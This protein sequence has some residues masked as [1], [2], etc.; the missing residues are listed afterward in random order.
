[1]YCVENLRC[2]ANKIIVSASVTVS[3]LALDFLTLHCDLSD[4]IRRD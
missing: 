1:M 2:A 3:I 4:A